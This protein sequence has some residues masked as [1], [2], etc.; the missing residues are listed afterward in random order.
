MAL[1][2]WNDTF[3]VGISEMDTQ[4]K[5]LVDMINQLYEAMSGG[6]GDNV[7]ADIL[8]GLVTYTRTH[9]A[10]EEKLMQK[11]GFPGFAQH[12][13]LHDELTQKVTELNDKVRNGKMVPSVSL[14]S[15]LKDWL[16]RHIQQEDMQ[17][18]RFITQPTGT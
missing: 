4:H 16:T 12:K 3:S 10:A 1:I 7:L 2:S 17:Y 11:Y 15:F 6:K 9:F 18:G 13:K 8:N 14:G 5:R